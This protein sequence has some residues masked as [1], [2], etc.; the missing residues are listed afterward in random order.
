M[1]YVMKNH[2]AA[3]DVIYDR[4]NKR[5][6]FYFLRMLSGD[7]SRAQDFTQEVF[8]KVVEKSSRYN[9]ER[10]FASWLFTIASNLCKNEYRRLAVR[11]S[12]ILNED[13]SSQNV[14]G[15]LN[16]ERTADQSLFVM[17][18]KRELMGLDPVQRTV[19][20]LRYQQEFSIKSISEIMECAEGTVKSRL[21]HIT[22]KLGHKLK[23]YKGILE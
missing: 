3:F 16:P 14:A 9:P 8:L 4:Y 12:S 2:T 11:K 5:L 6:F 23:D 18:L 21:Y 10:K 7:E 20:L 15:Q 13:L 22:K 19:F 17:A 1:R